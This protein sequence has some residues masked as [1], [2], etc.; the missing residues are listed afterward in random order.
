[1]IQRDESNL[2]TLS[3]VCRE[4]SKA[5]RKMSEYERARLRT[6]LRER[7]GLP[8]VRERALEN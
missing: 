5:I 6:A 4:T 7:Y 1:M 3:Q 2:W 8:P